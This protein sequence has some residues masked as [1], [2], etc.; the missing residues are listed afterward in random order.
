MKGPVALAQRAVLGALWNITTGV[1]AR[2]LTLI[3]TLLLTRYL[4]PSEY[5]EVM[6]ASVVVLSAHMLASAGL[7]QY[8]VS[9]P[10]AGREVTFHAT[11]LFT[12]LGLVAL[13]L[14]IALGRPICAFFGAPSAARYLPGLALGTLIDRLVFLPDR[15]LIRDMRFRAS[16]LTRSLGEVVFATSAV[17]LAALGRGG[18]ALVTATIARAAVKALVLVVL[19]DRR[20]WLTPCRLRRDR[21]RDLLAFGIPIAVAQIADFGSRRW[22][23]LIIANLYGPAVAGMYNLAYNLADI[24]ATQIGETIGD[25]LVPSFAHMAPEKRRPSLQR[26]LTLIT[27]VVAPLAIGLGAVAPTVV[28]TFFDPRWDA[29]WPMLAVLSAL[30]VARPVAWIVTPFLQ[31]LDRPRAQMILEVT[32]AAGLLVAIALLGQ[33]G[34][35]WACVAVGVAFGANA[36]ANV[37]V[38]AQMECVPMASFLV[39]LVR[40]VIACAPMVG[41]VIGARHLIAIAAPLPRGVGLAIETL[42]GAIVF[43]PSALLLAPDVARDLLSVL[44]RHLARRR[45]GPVEDAPPDPDA[46]KPAAGDGA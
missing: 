6:I 1:G 19:V 29:V 30:S 37:W 4:A 22:D 35:L 23:N 18:E 39:P 3:G 40:P 31:V 43:V 33:L 38:V 20:E 24:P 5:G 2:A 44:R 15:I 10:A 34:P 9:K 27:V 45:G 7:G 12:G 26:A 21:T 17:A 42:V 11:V 28:H 13:G 25:V 8:V 41:A 46:S 32:K 16:A 14:V 36:V